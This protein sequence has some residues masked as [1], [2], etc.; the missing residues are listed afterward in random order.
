[1][2]QIFSTI[3]EILYKYNLSFFTAFKA[4]ILIT[5]GKRQVIKVYTLH[6]KKVKDASIIKW[7]CVFLYIFIYTAKTWNIKPNKK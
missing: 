4:V 2:I 1:M 6:I 5:A 7:V 3:C